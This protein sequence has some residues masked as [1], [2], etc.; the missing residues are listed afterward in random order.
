MA[1]LASR[2]AKAIRGNVPHSFNVYLITLVRATT[3]SSF[4][5]LN[6]MPEAEPSGL[7]TAKVSPDAAFYSSDFSEFLLPYEAVRTAASP[8]ADLTAFFASTYAAAAD[9]AQW[10]RTELERR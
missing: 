5:S 2:S 1:R 9:L 10:N 7:K 8:E 6:T 3:N 4:L